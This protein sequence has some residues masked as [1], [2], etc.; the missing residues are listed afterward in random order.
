VL[1]KDAQ[2]HSVQWAVNA[3]FDKATTV[4]GLPYTIY[5]HHVP[6]PP[7]QWYWR[8]RIDGGGWSRTRTFQVPAQAAEFPQ[9]TL[10]QLRAR[11]PKTHPRLFI[12][13]K[14]LPHVQEYAAGAGK[15]RWAR[16]RA[17]ADQLAASEATPEPT[18]MGNARNPE[19]RDHWWSN[20]VQT[21]K[22]LQEA[23][24][25][26]FV[27]LLTGEEKYAA[28]AR[29]VTLAL[30]Q[31][32]PDGPTNFAVNCEAAKPMLHRLAR[33][34][35]WGY[36]LFSEQE[37]SQIRAM[38]LRRAND[39]W[40]SGEIGRGR[41]H[42]NQPYS[43]HGNRTWHKLAENAIA[44][45]GETAESDTFLHYAATKFFGAYP[46]WADDDGGWHE[47]LSYLSGYMV[48][49]RWWVHLA[50]QLGLQ[51][52][53]NPFFARVGDYA[54]YS[55]P[56]GTPDQGFGDLAFRPPSS[57]W[58]FLHYF[59]RAAGN[60]YW[61]WWLQQWKIPDEGGEPVLDFLWSS[62]KPVPA[63]A[64]SDLP[65]SKLFRGTGVA[66]LNTNLLDGAK[67]V[68]FRFKS[69]PMGRWSHGHDPHNSFTLNAYGVPLLVNNVYR[70]LYGSPFH[71]DWVWNAISQNS[72]L[73]N[74]KGQKPHSADL[75]GRILQSEFHDGF[76][77]VVGDATDSYEGRMKRAWRHV[78]FLKPDIVVLVDDL[79]ATEPSTFQ[80][81]LHAQTRFEMDEAGMQ[82]VV[83]REKAG[84]VIQYA[85]QH[86]LRLRQWTGYD[87]APDKQYLDSVRNAGIPEQ[88]HL[89]AATQQAA[90][91]MTVA[92]ILRVFEGKQRPEG[93]AS[94]RREGDAIVYAIGDASVAVRER[95]ATVRRAGREWQVKFPE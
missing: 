94:T 7:G 40:E 59:T 41:G 22:A 93:Q 39:A 48:K 58:A 34:Y 32:N 35:D 5:T 15:E 84:V 21:V 90:Q 83:D 25:L 75:G 74:G 82:A 31:W 6:F 13:R 91:S 18:V 87:P 19:T 63:K 64:P 68:Q 66:V 9:P 88:W 69:S 85:S 89:E 29:R 8:Y 56:P 52:F 50:T 36:D 38:L 43:S 4:S 61:A 11:I 24:V 86:P 54:L 67:N 95:G 2:T 81:M 30:A 65:P 12:H 49:T 77:Y 46:V 17:M 10:E 33:A 92:T 71:R 14:D 45:L 3:G 26:T 51:P 28:A 72:V 44:T 27:W 60:G 42:L 78:F 16:L 80:F 53:R 70:D 37:R 57:G 79:R 62:M 20:R 55:A 23:E 73:V 1:E 76:D 47:G